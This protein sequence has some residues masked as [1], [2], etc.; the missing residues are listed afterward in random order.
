MANV[1]V[2]ESEIGT[3]TV[4]VPRYTDVYTKPFSTEQRFAV[5]GIFTS[6][7]GFE[8]SIS[9]FRKKE[10]G[11]FE[12]VYTDSLA[13]SDL[14][15]ALVDLGRL[16]GAAGIP[17]STRDTILEPRAPT[18]QDRSHAGPDVARDPF[19]NLA[20]IPGPGLEPAPSERAE[21]IAPES[22][23][24]PSDVAD[25]IDYQV[26]QHERATA[27]W[28][29]PLEAGLR[30]VLPIPGMNPEDWRNTVR[31]GADI[32]RIGQGAAQ[33]TA[34]GALE[35]INRALSVFPETRGISRV[36]NVL[37]TVS[38]AA[39]II[40]SVANG[41]GLG[42]EAAMMVISAVS[43]VA[44]KKAKKLAKKLAEGKGKQPM[45]IVSEGMQ[46]RVIDKEEFVRDYVDAGPLSEAERK[47]IQK[48]VQE[49]HSGLDKRGQ[50]GKTTAIIVAR[51]ENGQIQLLVAS[52][53]KSV[54]KGV[55]E[56]M[57]PDEIQCPGNKRVDPDNDND[58]F[59][60]A[61][62]NGINVVVSTGWKIV[63]LFPSRNA[64]PLCR[65]MRAELGLIITDPA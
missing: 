57:N 48:R 5:Q 46:P 39:G 65:Q 26:S 2:P 3:F 51:D 63:E 33:G 32:L 24:A 4:N 11:G 35:D 61:E 47:R 29:V 52:S 58:H 20:R 8:A 42:G 1:S 27:D 6:E 36:V 59:H 49:L 7:K 10:D 19:E 14:N 50:G 18:P 38:T 62:M 53:E 21:M 31:S 16:R 55:R 41:Q 25:W 44:A 15:A 45:V 34:R 28:R 37:S 12:F 54:R 22:I 40:E 9:V 60:H 43:A 64:C 56:K 30:V 13:S 17:E 23:E